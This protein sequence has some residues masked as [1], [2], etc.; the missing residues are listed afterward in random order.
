MSLFLCLS[1]ISLGRYCREG[2]AKSWGFRKNIKRVN[3]DIGG[4]GRVSIE[5]GF[6]PSVHYALSGSVH[7]CIIIEMY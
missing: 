5:G 2:L 4:S 1:G 7:I 3:Y 6:K